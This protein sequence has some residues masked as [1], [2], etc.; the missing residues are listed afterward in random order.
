MNKNFSIIRVLILVLALGA[1]AAIVLARVFGPAAPVVA[2]TV[3]E[4][5]DLTD[6]GA[7]GQEA[8]VPENCDDRVKREETAEGYTI[9]FDYCLTGMERTDERIVEEVSAIRQRFLDDYEDLKTPE[10]EGRF[11]L[12]ITS[13]EFSFSGYPHVQSVLLNVY[14]DTAGAHPG[15][16]Y[17]TWTFDRSTDRLIAFRDLFQPEHNPLWTIHPMVK[18][19]LMSRE[20]ADES[21]I[22]AATGEEDFDN[23][24]NFV[25]DGDDLVILFEPGTVAAYAAGPQEVRIPLEDIQALVKPPFLDLQELYGDD[26]PAGDAAMMTRGALTASCEQSGGTWVDDYDECEY[27]GREWCENSEGIFKE[28]ESACRHDPEADFCTLQCV[29]VCQL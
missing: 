11:S 2:P 4:P 8:A 19:Q 29:P 28:C 6:V 22:E 20:Y 13:D 27:I 3:T 15:I 16:V 17:R 7:D 1:V 12:K 10:T 23:Y 26:A 24:R 18:E 14:V 21:Q 9:T 25:I 5:A